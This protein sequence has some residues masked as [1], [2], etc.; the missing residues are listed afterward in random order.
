MSTDIDEQQA[1]LAHSKLLTYESGICSP[2]EAAR[3]INKMIRA[4]NASLRQERDKLAAEL[5]SDVKKMAV[6]LA[7]S[8][9][10]ITR[11]DNAALRQEVE[12]LREAV[13]RLIAWEGA[14]ETCTPELGGLI[15][16]MIATRALLPKDKP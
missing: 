2:T 10:E 9:D 11:R 3:E 16:A 15:K 7:A 5:A 4:E 6:S 1:D 12:T 14:V 13:T 8:M